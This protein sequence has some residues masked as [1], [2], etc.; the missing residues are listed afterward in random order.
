MGL[1]AGIGAAAL[2]GGTMASANAAKGRKTALNNIA[3]TPGIDPNEITGEALSSIGNNQGT[4]EGI[5]GRANKFSQEQVNAML[6]QAIP[7]WSG[8][9]A[10]RTANTA[11]LLA[12]RL[13][14]DVQSAVERSAASRALGGGYGGSGAAQNLTLRDLGRTSLDA[15]TLGAQQA[16]TIVQDTPHANLFNLSSLLGPTPTDL[17]GIRSGERTLKLEQLTGATNAPGPGDV[18]GKAA[19]QIGG[20]LLG[21]MGGAGGILGKGG[22]GANANASSW[23]G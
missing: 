22:A 8:I 17:A 15:T 9:Q 12:G 4:A 18:Y 23:G 1:I 2:I 6:E 16:N 3:N 7:G 21:S 19:Q 10:K 11:D 13:P 5:A 14:S 20:S